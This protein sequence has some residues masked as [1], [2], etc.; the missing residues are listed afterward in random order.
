MKKST[1]PAQRRP[2]AGRWESQ[3]SAW[4][5]DVADPPELPQPAAPGLGLQFELVNGYLPRTRR[6]GRRISMRPVLPAR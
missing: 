2:R 5:R 6:T 3:L 4:M 1:A